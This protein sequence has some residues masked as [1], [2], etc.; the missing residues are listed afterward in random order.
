MKAQVTPPGRVFDQH[1]HELSKLPELLQGN[2]RGD[3]LTKVPRNADS[4][5]CTAHRGSA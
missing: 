4:Q 3:G 1:R 2:D 5:E